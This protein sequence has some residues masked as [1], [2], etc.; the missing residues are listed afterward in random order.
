ML[1]TAHGAV[2]TPA[3]MPVGSLGVVKG[4]EAE[5]LQALGFQ[6]ILNN[7][8][9]LYLR[10]GHQVVAAMGGLHAFTAWSGAL[11]TAVVG[12]RSSAWQNSARSRTTA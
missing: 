1:T 6:L 10:P 11:L 4:V 8:Y 5:D 2:D 9:H 12:F 7:A 3:F